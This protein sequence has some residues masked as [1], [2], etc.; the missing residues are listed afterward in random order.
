MVNER[1]VL[2][3]YN[4]NTEDML[5]YR[6]SAAKISF[7]TASAVCY[8]DNVDSKQTSSSLKLAEFNLI[9]VSKPV[10]LSFR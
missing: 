7:K 2:M 3:A 9:Q 5:L 10:T 1:F 4:D 6:H 8:L